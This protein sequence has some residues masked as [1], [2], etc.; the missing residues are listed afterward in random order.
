MIK[1]GG[2]VS[3]NAFSIQEASADDKYTH[4]GYGRYKEKGKEKDKNAATFKKD[5]DKYVPTGTGTTKGG[6]KPADDGKPKVNIFDKPEPRGK[7]TNHG[8]PGEGGEEPF[9]FGTD[10]EKTGKVQ[11][12][13]LKDIMPKSDDK[14]F[15]GKSDISKV[16]KKHR[17]Q[18]SMKIDKL[19]ELSQ[20]ARAAGKDAPNYNLC[21]ITIPGTNLYCDGNLGIKREDMPQFKGKPQAGTPAS[22]LPVDDSGGVDT[23]PLFK[24][25]LKKK[26]IKSVETEI[27]SDSLKATQSELV[28]SKVAGMSK[29]LE[30][31]PNHPGITAP[32]YVSRDG[33]VIDGHHRWAAVTSNAIRRGKPANMNVVVLDMDSKDV[34]PMANKF[35]KDMGISSEK[36]AATDKKES[37]V[38]DS[39]NSR[40]GDPQ[41]NKT[42]RNL[43]QKAGITPQKLGS[44]E[45]KKSMIQAA[46]AALI[47]GNFSDEARKLVAKLENKPEWAKKPN[48]D[49]L[50]PMSDPTW[51][52]KSDAINNNSAYASE[53]MKPGEEIEKFGTSVSKKSSWDGQDA[54]DAI[55]YTLK[56]N[57]FKKSASEI[58]SIFENVNKN[59]SLKHILG[60]SILPSK[61][62]AHYTGTRESAI[63][64]FIEKNNINAVELASYVR[65]GKLP[66]RLNVATAV[67]GRPGNKIQ[68]LIIQN[69]GNSN[70]SVIK[71]AVRPISRIA[72]EISNDWKKVNYAAKPYLQAMLSLNKISDNYGQD[73]GR[74]VVAYFLSNASQW[75]GPV[76]KRIKSELKKMLK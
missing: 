36:A 69:F 17:K 45:Y 26:G 60:E 76:A 42:V 75:K 35:A 56:M 63:K 67:S 25:M 51:K 39:T 43:A 73:D 58:Q 19:A 74:G 6:D 15:S 3:Q 55:A 16:D 21:D 9:G 27:P 11:S 23:E 18:I 2:L 52:E 66:D 7:S 40:A 59:T 47:D 34:I 30:K 70:E 54:V 8:T 64:D 71:E 38:K 13:K 53:Y 24:A 10:D 72:N 46:V 32:I 20:K 5:G 22:K 68:K 4:I 48:Y 61:E 49:S 29:A 14:A 12:T 65:K 1:L 41:T 37:P 44:K 33:Y 50:P 62:I 28:G 57:G 31:D